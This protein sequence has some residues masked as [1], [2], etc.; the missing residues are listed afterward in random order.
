M[1]SNERPDHSLSQPQQLV[2][3][4]DAAEAAAQRW[5]GGLQL[6]SLFSSSLGIAVAAQVFTCAWAIAADDA[7]D[8]AVLAAGMVCFAA[9]AGLQLF[10][11]RQANGVWVSGLGSRVVLGTA[12][13]A[14]TAYVLSL[15]GALWAVLSGHVGLAAVCAGLGGV[16][17]AWSGMRW[18]RRYQDVPARHAHAETVAV[19]VAAGALALLGAVLLLLAAG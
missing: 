2:D 17:Y 14:A 13:A 5:A 1:E 4:A 8:L 10:R 7:V 15:G 6:P 9:V 12:S 11:F 18:W 16:G 19:L 3:T